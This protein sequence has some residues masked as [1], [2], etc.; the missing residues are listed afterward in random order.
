MAESYT[1]KQ[2]LSVR[3]AYNLARTRHLAGALDKAEEVYKRILDAMPDNAETVAMMASIAF[4]KG[5]DRAGQEYLDQAIG[6]SRAAIQRMPQD[7]GMRASLVN[8][9]LARGRISEAEALMS[10]LD[11]PLNPMRATDEEFFARRAAGIGD[12]LP[13]M[14]ISTLPKSASESIWNQLAEGLGLAQC[15]LSLGLFPDCCLVPARVAEAAEGGLVTK[16]HIAPTAHNLAAFAQ[17]GIERVIVH[18]RDPRQATLSWAHFARDDINRRLMAPLWRKIVPPA[19]VLGGDLGGQIDWC[20]ENYLPLL[21]R[22][23][24]DWRAA[25][26]DPERPISVLFM[27]FEKFRAE[28]AGYFERVLEFYGVPRERFAAEAQ[29]E[30]VHLRK[31]EIDEWRGVFTEAQRRRAWDSIPGDLAE[32]FGWRP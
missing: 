25:D 3:Q 8:L 13:L 28:P 11:I 2:T 5:E 20:I 31:G 22:F 6:L 7:L 14:V 30:V 26:A 9:L 16:E 12:N 27:S 1:T 19:Q 23:L 18:H 21:V 15:Y 17:S 29:A 10:G 32:A 24:A 4:C